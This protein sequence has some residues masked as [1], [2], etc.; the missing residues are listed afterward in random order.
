MNAMQR[1][2]EIGEI[3]K[4]LER[5]IPVGLFGKRNKSPFE[6]LIATVLS[7]RTRD[8]NTAKAAE[9]L[10]SKYKTP[11][12]IA[13]APVKEIEKLIKPSGFYRVKARR[14]REISR[15]IAEQHNSRVPK[16]L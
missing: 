1:S 4:I 2:R 8:E 12:Q 13:N 15:I 5:R 7:Q 10:F 6:V 14:I 9:Q 16:S 11:K 3:I